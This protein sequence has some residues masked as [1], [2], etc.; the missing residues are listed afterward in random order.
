MNHAGRL[1]DY[2]LQVTDWASVMLR[3]ISIGLVPF[4][5][6]VVLP[7]EFDAMIVC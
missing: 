6:G 2:L 5:S 4:R 7:R 1:F 3:L